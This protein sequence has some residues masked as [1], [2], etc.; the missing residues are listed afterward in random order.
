MDIWIGPVEEGN[1]SPGLSLYGIIHIDFI[2]FT[3]SYIALLTIIRLI[4]YTWTVQEI[5]CIAL[6][7]Q[8]NVY[9][10]RTPHVNY[11]VLRLVELTPNSRN[12]SYW[13]TVKSRKTDSRVAD[14]SVLETACRSRVSTHY[15]FLFIW[16][17]MKKTLTCL[18]INDKGKFENWHPWLTSLPN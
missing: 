5:D 12:K 7:W 4:T 1:C 14:L 10:R 13:R 3:S 8:A 17:S 6:K 18:I 15:V 11:S 9:W 16:P 2:V